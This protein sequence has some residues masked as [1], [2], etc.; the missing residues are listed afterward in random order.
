MT[1]IEEIQYYRCVIDDLMNQ[2]E[3][4]KRAGRRRRAEVRR[5]KKRLI[6]EQARTRIAIMTALSKR[7]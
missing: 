1:D 2:I 4:M 6:E 3:C 5:L 7:G